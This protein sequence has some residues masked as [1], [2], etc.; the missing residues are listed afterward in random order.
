MQPPCSLFGIKRYKKTYLKFEFNAIAHILSGNYPS[1][2]G[3][4]G[5]D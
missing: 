4:R 2:Q 1:T 3:H 5:K